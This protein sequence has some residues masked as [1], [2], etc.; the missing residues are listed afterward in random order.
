MPLVVAVWN[1]AQFRKS[2]NV[3]GVEHIELINDT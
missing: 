2:V 1:L 3:S